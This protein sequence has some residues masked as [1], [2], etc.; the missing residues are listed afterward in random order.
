LQAA[1]IPR[2]EFMFELLLRNEFK[3]GARR[4]SLNFAG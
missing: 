2:C 1:G 3:D 4:K